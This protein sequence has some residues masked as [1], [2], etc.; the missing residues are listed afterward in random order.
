[1]AGG[2]IFL[3]QVFRRLAEG[4]SRR[5]ICQ[6]QFEMRLLVQ[7]W[8]DRTDSAMD[9]TAYFR[10]GNPGSPAKNPKAHRFSCGFFRRSNLQP[11]RDVQYLFTSPAIQEEARDL[12]IVW[13]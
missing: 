5:E 6:R 2:G 11:A 13:P 7:D 4:T 8:V 12:S 10:D 3:V 9:Y 1:M